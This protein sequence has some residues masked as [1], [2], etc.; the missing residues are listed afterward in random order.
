MSRN[1][2]TEYTSFLGTGWSFPPAFSRAQRGVEMTS[3]EEDIESSLRILLSTSVGERI[4]QPE[5]G[6]NIDHLIFEPLNTTLKTY[7]TGLIEQAVL[8]FEPR[9]ELN[10][11]SLESDEL[12]GRVDIIIDYTVRTTNSRYNLVY[13]FYRNEAENV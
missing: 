2:S 5:Y 1:D 4:L 13:P 11:I 8:F 6:C 9:I 12:E 10:G 3:D 7:V